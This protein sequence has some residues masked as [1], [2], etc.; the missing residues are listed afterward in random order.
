MKMKHITRNDLKHFAL[1][2]Y[3]LYSCGYCKLQGLIKDANKIGYNAGIYGWN[4]DVYR[5]DV[6]SRT[7]IIATGY[8]QPKYMEIN[9]NNFNNIVNNL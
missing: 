7:I 2:G 5:Y 8:R 3:E 9:Q 1:L 4:Y 6:G